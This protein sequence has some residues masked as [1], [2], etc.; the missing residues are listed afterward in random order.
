M[1][2]PRRT[3]TTTTRRSSEDASF[4][5]IVF[6]KNHHFA[7]TG[8]GQT[9][10]KHFKQEIN[11]FTTYNTQWPGGNSMYWSMFTIGYADLRN[12]TATDFFFTKSAAQ[13]VFGPFRIWSE[14][15]GGGGCPN[16]LTGA[17]IYLQSVWAGYGGLR[18]NDDSL[19]VRRRHFFSHLCINAIILPR[20][21]RDNHREN[22]KKVPF[23]CR[24]QRRRDVHQTRRALRYGGWNTA[25]RGWTMSSP[26]ARA[27]RWR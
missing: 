27:R 26:R 16:F 7:K 9:K 5:A 6:A 23:S 10:G 19:E 18:L 21:A 13:N 8:S 24:L 20:Q 22:S 1:R 11:A 3:W 25:G 12:A 2:S 14:A 17:G 4:C 15:P